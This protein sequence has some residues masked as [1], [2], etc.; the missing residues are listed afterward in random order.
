MTPANI[1]CVSAHLRSAW[2]QKP[3]VIHR[4]AKD[5][6]LKNLF[7]P[8]LLRIICISVCELKKSQLST[9]HNDANSYDLETQTLKVREAAKIDLCRKDKYFHFS[10]SRTR[11]ERFLW[12]AAKADLLRLGLYSGNKD[13]DRFSSRIHDWDFP[14]TYLSGYRAQKFWLD[15]R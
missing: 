14:L 4:Y 11:K 15:L 9:L 12:E 1:L 2:Q 3:G 10:Q 13:L 8:V 6:I 7:P 5:T